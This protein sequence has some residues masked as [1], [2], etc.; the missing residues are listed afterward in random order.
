M[1]I[2]SLL[3]FLGCA[4]F[5]FALAAEDAPQLSPDG[6]AA[7]AHGLALQQEAASLRAEA[8]TRLAEE[9]AACQ[10]RFLVNACIADAKNRHLETLRQTRQMEAEGRDLEYRART[11]ERAL[12]E[13][14]R[15]RDAAAK[16]E[17]LPQQ[18]AD[19]AAR[20]AA[21]AAQR[22]K[23]LADKA[24]EAQAGEQRIAAR[25][26]AYTKKQARHAEKRK[27]AAKNPRKR[28]SIPAP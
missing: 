7:L 28:A 17:S 22:D 1:N 15:A 19:T 26:A 21:Q 18:E 20:R 6:A 9:S 14:Q 2:R 23:R 13:T 8:D 12:K 10:Q 24:A 27:K 5:H 3:F 11:E 25:K 16:T 4:S